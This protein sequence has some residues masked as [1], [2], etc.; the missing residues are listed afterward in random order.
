[1]ADTSL[2]PVLP[3][4]T[5]L[6]CPLQSVHMTGHCWQTPHVMRDEAVLLC[7]LCQCLPAGATFMVVGTSMWSI[8]FGQISGSMGLSMVQV[9]LQS[10]ESANLVSVHAAE[11]DAVPARVLF[12]TGATH[13]FI[14]SSFAAKQGFAL[15][16]PVGY[17]VTL[18]D[19]HSVLA[20]GCTGALQLRFPGVLAGTVLIG[21]PL[22]SSFHVVLGQDWLSGHHAVLGAKTGRITV[23]GEGVTAVPVVQIAGSHVVGVHPGPFVRSP[24]P[25]H[26]TSAV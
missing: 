21:I 1:M 24:G 9:T 16:T 5:L 6:V 15:S 2:G 20:T 26:S 19:G 22:S 23:G 12:D 11:L 3:A 7:V 25:V 17:G 14:D 4:G 10:L 8:P 13:S 18:G